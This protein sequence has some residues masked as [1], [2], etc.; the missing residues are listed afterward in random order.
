MVR[1]PAQQILRV[2]GLVTLCGGLLFGVMDL[3]VFAQS[4]QGTASSGKLE[5]VSGYGCYQ[6]GD[7]ETPEKAKAVAEQK[8][9]ERAVESHHVLVQAFKTVENYQ[10]KKEL[11]ETASAGLLKD[12]KIEKEEKKPDQ[13][14][15]VTI[16]ARLSPVTI[17][18]T[19]R[20]QVMA[21]QVNGEAATT[22]VLSPSS[23]G[24]I[25]ILTNKADGQFVE[26]ERL[27][28]TVVSDTDGYLKL[29]YYQADNTVVHLVP[30]IASQDVRVKAGE[31]YVFGGG[32]APPHVVIQGPYGH[33]TIKAMVS[34]QR[35]PV[36]MNSAKPVD[37]SRTY[38]NNQQLATRGGRLILGT[39]Q[40]IPIV[41][42]SK[43]LNEYRG[44]R[45]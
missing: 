2:I 17:E 25:R 31:P 15:C 26:D 38:M 45:K 39:E 35:F 16:S 14:I 37:D 32:N 40:S 6:Y 11:I 41:T 30:N 34:Q 28:I 13:T 20:Q 5:T 43:T 8:A 19:V 21:K 24:G 3:Q 7:R 29:D 36:E 27:I 33:E 18:E 10:L 9:R 23:G 44:V 12:I 4:A 42:V 1:Q 22:K